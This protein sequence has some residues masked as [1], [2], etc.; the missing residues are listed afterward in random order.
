[1]KRLLA[2]GLKLT[3]PKGRCKNESPLFLPMKKTMDL[4]FCLNIAVL[5]ESTMIT[6]ISIRVTKKT[7]KTISEDWR[8]YTTLGQKQV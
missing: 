1:M 8:S 2:Q 5:L 3:Y 7:P 4:T 6:F